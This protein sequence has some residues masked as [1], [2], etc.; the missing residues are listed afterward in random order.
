MD[1]P[2]LCRLTCAPQV[3]GLLPVVLVLGL[4]A[5]GG[6]GPGTQQG[7]PPPSADFTL[8]VTPTSVSVQSG[9]SASAS[10]SA[11]GSNGF[12]SQISVQVSGLPAGVAVSPSPVN[13][14]PGTPQSLT[15]SANTSTSASNATLTVTGTAGS[16]SHTTNLALTILAPVTSNTPPF[17]TRYVRTDAATPYF[18]WLNSHWIVY[19]PP[20]SRLFVTD[21]NSNRV[22]ALDAHTQ[23]LVGTMMVPGAFGI[24]DTPD[25]KTLY[26]GTQIG[27]VYVIDPV[28]MSVTKRFPSAG[29]GP[30]GFSAYSAL[31]MAD[32]RLALLGGQGGF[33]S[34][35][36]Y[37]EVAIWGTV[38]FL[39]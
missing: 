4:A 10:V 7:P 33:Q 22:F 20:T 9:N 34:V 6:G 14:T 11:T 39:R 37:G 29:I 24:D 32:G 21:P 5:C 18:A 16:L 8:S 28:A 2:R 25:H 31:V 13:L 19:N 15:L 26:V 27:D 1:K 17:R 30:N 3:W 36:G 23:Q 35:D 12:S 38:I